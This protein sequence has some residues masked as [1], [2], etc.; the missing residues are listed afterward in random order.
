[1]VTIKQQESEHVTAKI[2]RL[3]H[4]II[5]G[6][7]TQS[8]W[9]EGASGMKAEFYKDQQRNCKRKENEEYHN[10]HEILMSQSFNSYFTAL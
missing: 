2:A 9:N 1:M 3:N 8:I 7:T 4:D 5:P 10:R 6:P